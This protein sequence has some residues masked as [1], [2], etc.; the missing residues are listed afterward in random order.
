MAITSQP[1]GVNVAAASIVLSPVM[2]TALEAMNN[3]SIY[4]IGTTV[5]LG[6]INT[7]DPMIMKKRKLP[8][9]ISDGLV[10]RL[11]SCMRP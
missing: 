11:N 7:K 2:L 3:A 1:N 5:H 10:R 4:L 6:S 8:D 9:S